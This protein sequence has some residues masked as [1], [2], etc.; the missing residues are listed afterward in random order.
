MKHSEKAKKWF[1]NIFRYNKIIFD[2][3]MRNFPDIV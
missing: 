3:E 1:L 2:R